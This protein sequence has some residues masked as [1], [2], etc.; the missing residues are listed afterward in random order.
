MHS[1]KRK[2]GTRA[3]VRRKGT[4]KRIGTIRLPRKQTNLICS[5]QIH[6]AASRVTPGTS[7]RIAQNTNLEKKERIERG[8]SQKTKREHQ[9]YV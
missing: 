1:N 3:K 7:G 4:R 5:V 9:N 8:S 6:R 2:K